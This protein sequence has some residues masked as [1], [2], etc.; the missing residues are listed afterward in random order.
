MNNTPDR[1][2]KPRVV[3]DYPVIVEGHDLNGNKYNEN[4]MLANLSASGLYMKANRIIENGSKLSVTVLLT[5][6]LVEKDTPKIATSGVVVRIE[7][8][9]DGSCGVAVKFNSYRFL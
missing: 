7:P 1:R 8:Q 4:G 6:D 5:S 3:C 9:S 2:R